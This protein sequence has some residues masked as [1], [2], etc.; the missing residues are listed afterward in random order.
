[1]QHFEVQLDATKETWRSHFETLKR[2]A[3]LAGGRLAVLP[4]GRM[5][6]KGALR[7]LSQTLPDPAPETFRSASPVASGDID[8]LV[9]KV[10]ATAG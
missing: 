4:E 6:S 9:A 8:P 10:T 5:G 2:E 1:M 7:F 3:G